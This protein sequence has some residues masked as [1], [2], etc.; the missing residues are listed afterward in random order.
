LGGK[1]E[2][3]VSIR[4]AHRPSVRCQE[5]PRRATRPPRLIW[6]GYEGVGRALGEQKGS[7]IIELLRG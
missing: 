2:S 5:K 3:W 6:M 7:L 1:V 4:P